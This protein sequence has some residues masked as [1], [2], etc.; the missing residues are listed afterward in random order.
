YG[1]YAV[2]S[3]EPEEDAIRHV[4][5]WARRLKM[6]APRVIGW[7]FPAVSQ[8]Q[9]NVFGMHGY[10]AA[11]VLKSGEPDEDLGTEIFWQEKQKYAMITIRES[12]Q[13]PFCLIPNA[14]KVL[15][16][17]MKVNGLKEKRDKNVIS[18]FEREYEIDGVWHMDVHIAVE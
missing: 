4:N 11:L 15:M 9:A 16:A 3:P 2:I 18:C 8:E 14:Y 17:H 12:Q 5:E 1:K 10:A 7:D 6:D 13:S